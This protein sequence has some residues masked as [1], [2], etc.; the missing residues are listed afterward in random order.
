MKSTLIFTV[1]LAVFP[2]VFLLAEEKLQVTTTKKIENCARRSRV[3][4]TLY[5]Q[6]TVSLNKSFSTNR[7]STISSGCFEIQWRKIRFII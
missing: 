7:K 1:L 6:Y 4:D 5:M 2:S 3:G